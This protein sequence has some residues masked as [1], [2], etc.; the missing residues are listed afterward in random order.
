M[1]SA[2]GFVVL[3]RLLLIFSLDGSSSTD[4]FEF[5]FLQNTQESDLCLTLL[6]NEVYRKGC[7]LRREQHRGIE[8]SWVPML[9]P[10]SPITGNCAQL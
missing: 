6:S 2:Q 4:S 7:L 5:M 9:P 8:A 10:M 3:K 1:R